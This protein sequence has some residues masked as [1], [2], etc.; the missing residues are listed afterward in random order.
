MFGTSKNRPNLD[1]RTPYLLQ[2]YLEK[3]KKIP[4][5]FSIM[6]F[7]PQRFGHAKGYFLESVAHHFLNTIS[8]NEM[9]FKHT[10]DNYA[11]HV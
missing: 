11:H 7:I 5:Y 10:S 3:Y 1:P 6:Y 4:N 9:C 2:K 8:K